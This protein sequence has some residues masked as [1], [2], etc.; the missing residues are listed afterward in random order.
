MIL[1]FFKKIFSV[2][3]RIRENSHKSIEMPSPPQ[4]AFFYEIDK[5]DRRFKQQFNRHS[6][7]MN[8]RFEKI[9]QELDEL[10]KFLRD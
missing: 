7:K 2:I 8:S 5:C 10:H 4:P 9:D 6:E 1:N 3:K